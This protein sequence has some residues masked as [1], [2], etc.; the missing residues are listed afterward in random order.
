MIN[1]CIF[2]D[3][4]YR[5]LHPLTF[6]K[7]AYTLKVGVLSPLQRFQYYF[8]HGNIN[9]HC[10]DYISQLLAH[11]EPGVPIN[12]INTGSPCLFI[13]GRVIM[14]QELCD[15]L[16]SEDT[17]HNFMFTYK[18]TVIALF[19]RSDEL[20]QMK[21]ILNSTPGNDFL[22]ETFRP[23]CVTKELDSCRIIQSPWDIIRLN[24]DCIHDD[25]NSFN[26]TGSIRGHL[27]VH[28]VN[29]MMTKICLLTH[30]QPLKTLW[31]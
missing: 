25:F 31:F 23:Y 8:K 20:H 18:G 19:L 2:E 15:Q 14:T 5:S 4:H 21:E 12:K 26:Y 3:S 10:R 11:V 17:S 29:F 24:A 6:T 1:F 7:P 9:F 27:S 16:L 13:N 30:S 28:F 22:I